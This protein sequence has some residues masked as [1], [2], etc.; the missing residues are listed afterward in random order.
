[1]ADP[2]AV[3]QCFR[4]SL[5]GS[6]WNAAHLLLHNGIPFNTFKYFLQTS[7]DSHKRVTYAIHKLTHHPLHH[8]PDTDD[9]LQYEEICDWILTR[10][11]KWA[12]LLEGGIVWQ[13]VLHALLYSTNSELFIT[14]GPSEDAFSWGHVLELSDGKLYD[15]ILRDNK[16]D[17]I[18]GVYKL[19]TGESFSPGIWKKVL[20]I[21]WRLQ[22]S[23]CLPVLVAMSICIPAF[24]NVDWILDT[25]LRVM[26]ST[27]PE[28][29]P[30]TSC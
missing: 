20:I 26:V 4:A 18:C 13:L 9:Y 14:Q 17:L 25:L 28:W 7:S 6:I 10:P 1:M 23:N 22:W 2:A 3:L 5:G 12:A 21:L 24:R 8:I 29:D 27:P 15:D 19:E 11:Y 16:K 30:W